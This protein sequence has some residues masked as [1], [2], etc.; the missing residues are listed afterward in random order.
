MSEPRE[1]AEQLEDAAAGQLKMDIGLW[2]RLFTDAAALIGQ[3][4]TA[5][6]TAEREREKYRELLNANMER[7]R[8][9][10]TRA[11][12]AEAALATAREETRKH[13]EQVRELR[14]WV[15]GASW[16]ARAEASKLNITP[17][18]FH[19][20]SGMEIAYDAV[21]AQFDVQ[22]DAD[23]PAARGEAK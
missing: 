23:A 18:V 1:I 20:L 4:A 5:L 15:S 3:Q 10:L 17:D 14:K 9:T 12:Q 7:A 6:A 13:D 19:R 11:E 21:R 2:M 22:F 8:I 16:K